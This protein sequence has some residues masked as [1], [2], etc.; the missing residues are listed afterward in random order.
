M[1]MT[2]A[3]RYQSDFEL[4]GCAEEGRKAIGYSPVN[5]YCVQR[6]LHDLVAN[7]SD[8]S[9]LRKVV[10]TMYFENVLEIV[11]EGPDIQFRSTYE[12]ILVLLDVS[13]LAIEANFG[14]AYRL[15]PDE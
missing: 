6:W 1:E 3:E 13:F 11:E 15:V 5:H 9:G 10:S 8:P 7:W 14:T 2:N 4:A 12:C